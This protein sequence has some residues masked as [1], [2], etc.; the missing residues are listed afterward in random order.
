MNSLSLTAN[1]R[2]W[3]LPSAVAGGIGAVALGAIL[4]LPTSGQPA[5]EKDA[6]AA[7]T[8]SVPANPRVGRTCLAQRPPRPYGVEELPR[9]ACR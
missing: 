1:S 2:S 4:I 7:P 9:P 3:W 6:P 5:P 8:V